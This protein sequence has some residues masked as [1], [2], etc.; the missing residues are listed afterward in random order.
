MGG[1][2]LSQTEIATIPLLYAELGSQQ[3]VA[4]ALGC[5]QKTI[6]NHLR[7]MTGEEWDHIREK[8]RDYVV[9]RSVELLYDVLGML[10]D[11]LPEASM[12]DLLRAYQTFIAKL[13]GLGGLGKK[14]AAPTGDLEAF[15]AETDRRRRQ[16]AIDRAI[17]SGDVEC[18]RI[19]A[20]APATG[21][22]V[23]APELPGTLTEA[24]E[25]TGEP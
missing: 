12:R 3:K 9:T 2:H 7:A 8:Q 10:G 1:R 25:E 24:N 14:E 21:G 6:S 20:S 16:E 23:K 15:L 4:D 11:K 13:Q 17:A 5:H 18:L 19:F 22:D